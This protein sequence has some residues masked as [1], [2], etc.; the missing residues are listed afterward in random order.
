GKVTVA[1]PAEN[2]GTT[3]PRYE[4]PFEFTPGHLEMASAPGGKT[5]VAGAQKIVRYLANG[6][7][8]PTFGQGGTVVVPRP[9]GDVFVLAGVAVDSLGRVVLA[10]LVRP[11]PT[12]STPDPVLSQAAVMRFNVDG[13]PDT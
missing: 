13:T 6:K 12:N 7:P 10:G 5:V 8:D 11:L 1:F 4:L 2:A 3:G 9:P